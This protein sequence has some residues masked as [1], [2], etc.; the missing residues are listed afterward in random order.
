M[1]QKSTKSIFLKKVISYQGIYKLCIIAL[2]NENS[3][4]LSVLNDSSYET[5]DSV[6]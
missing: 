3:N 2:K 4:R 6:I 5:I 1:C